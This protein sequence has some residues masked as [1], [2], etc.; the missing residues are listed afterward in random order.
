MYTWCVPESAGPGAS[1]GSSIVWLYHDHVHETNGTNA[2]LVGPIIITAAGAARSDGSAVRMQSCAPTPS[3]P[4]ASFC[5]QC[6][7]M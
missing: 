4:E 7:Q 3:S 2:G 1:D 5:V 6:V